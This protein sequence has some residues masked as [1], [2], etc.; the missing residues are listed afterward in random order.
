MFNISPEY[1][2]SKKHK[3]RP[4]SNADKKIQHSTNKTFNTSISKDLITK[5]NNEIKCPSKYYLDLS[6]KRKHLLEQKKLFYNKIYSKNFGK[7]DVLG[8]SE[9]L[10]IKKEGKGKSILKVKDNSLTRLS[11]TKTYRKINLK[12]KSLQKTQQSQEELKSNEYSYDYYG[13][14][15]NSRIKENRKIDK[16]CE[17]NDEEL[18]KI[19]NKSSVSKTR[20]VSVSMLLNREK[21][22]PTKIDIKPEDVNS[23]EMKIKNEFIIKYGYI[24]DLFQKILLS[25]SWIRTDNQTAFINVTNNLSK[26]FESFNN[27]LLE[28]ILDEKCLQSLYHFCEEIISWQK[29]SLDEINFWKKQCIY[30]RDKLKKAEKELIKTSEEVKET[31]NKIIKYDLN[32]VNAGKLFE[33]KAKRLEN[34]YINEASKNID[35]IYKLTE[36]INQLKIVLGKNKKEKLNNEELKNQVKRLKEELAESKTIIIKNKYNQNNKDKLNEVYIEELE[37]KIEGFE[38]EKKF[39]GEKENKISEELIRYKVKVERMTESIK[40][41]D[42]IILELH[43]NLNKNKAISIVDN[44]VK[45]PVDTKFISEQKFK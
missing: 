45:N 1:K 38:N 12:S 29:I 17:I 5:I 43:K 37:E 44:F 20:P 27:I 18:K 31:N 34:E 6:H 22:I 39:W 3:Q 30:L 16:L 40:E 23:D 4:I 33:L 15:V 11:S 36:E 25:K 10:N 35:T 24:L 19:Y 7:S 42:K 14:T 13:N 41:K 2:N 8:L 32:K 21:N 26:C 9:F 28:K